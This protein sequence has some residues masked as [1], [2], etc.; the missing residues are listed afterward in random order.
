MA[1]VAESD[2]TTATGEPY[3]I[4]RELFEFGE[5]EGLAFMSDFDGET[6]KGKFRRLDA[7]V[8]S[9]LTEKGYVEIEEV[10]TQK[11]VFLTDDGRHTLRAFRYVLERRDEG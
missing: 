4:K 10:G 6:D 5:R 1:H 9:P 7:H 2:R 3:R 8:V 11:R